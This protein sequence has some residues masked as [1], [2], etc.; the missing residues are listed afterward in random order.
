MFLTCWWD[1][2]N[3]F[4]AVVAN[5]QY[6]RKISGYLHG[7]WLALST[8]VVWSKDLPFQSS[9]RIN[10]S[11]EN[12]VG[13][14]QGFIVGDQL[15]V[16]S[17]FKKGDITNLARNSGFSGWIG[18]TTNWLKHKLMTYILNAVLHGTTAVQ[19]MFFCL[20]YLERILSQMD[21]FETLI[22]P[23]NEVF[24]FNIWR[25]VMSYAFHLAK[26]RYPAF[27]SISAWSLS[28][29]LQLPNFEPNQWRIFQ[30]VPGV[31]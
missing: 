6:N 14:L 2:F 11:G 23:P 16:K 13:F 30:V 20:I 15:V 22:V 5:R 7:R 3:I 8:C 25:L 9:G 29:P 19:P 12:T 1:I 27:E 26:L 18:W 4:I 10:S 24:S 17:P 21:S 28:Q 31:C